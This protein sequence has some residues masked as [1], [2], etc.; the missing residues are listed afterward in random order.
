M[1]VCWEIVGRGLYVSFC[2]SL[3]SLCVPGKIARL[4][5]HSLL[6][7]GRFVSGPKGN[8][9]GTDPVMMFLLNFVFGINLTLRSFW[10]QSGVK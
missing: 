4:T 3:L 10:K 5:S 7:L 2:L 9:E 1:V 6:G 8:N